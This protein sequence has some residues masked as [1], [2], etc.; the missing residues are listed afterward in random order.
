VFIMAGLANQC[1]I[2]NGGCE[3]E[4][5]LDAA[6]QVLCHSF[7]GRTLMADG[8]RC[9]SKDADCNEHEFRCSSG[10]CI[11]YHLTCDSI[12]VCE[13]ESDEESRYCGMLAM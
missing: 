7:S 1:R 5:S 10:G 11:P 6:G 2:L 9:T 3:D 13:D 4:C 12:P 8:Q